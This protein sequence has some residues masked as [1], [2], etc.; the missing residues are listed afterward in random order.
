EFFY[1]ISANAIIDLAIMVADEFLNLFGHLATLTHQ[2]E[3]LR[4]QLWRQVAV[5]VAARQCTE[6]LLA[7]CFKCH[8]D[9]LRLILLYWKDYRMMPSANKSTTITSATS[10]V[11]GCVV[12]CA[13]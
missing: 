3:D 13:I 1:Q 11:T 4:H 5:G 10:Q 8:S 12:F 2:P 7:I 6:G 9:P